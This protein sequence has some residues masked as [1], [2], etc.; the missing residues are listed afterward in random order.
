MRQQEE[1]THNIIKPHA[2][3]VGDPQPREQLFAEVLPQENS[4]PH[5]RLPSLGVWPQEEEPPEHSA[6]KANGA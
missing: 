1:C 6:L 2:P 5:V 4:E 3:Q